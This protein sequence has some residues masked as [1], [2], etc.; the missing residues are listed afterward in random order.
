M[1]RNIIAITLLSVIVASCG[2]KLDLLPQQ[3]VAEEVA[4]NSDANVKKVLNCA[5]DAVSDG[6]LY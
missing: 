3:S 4:L 1:K 6:D 5:Y 2:K